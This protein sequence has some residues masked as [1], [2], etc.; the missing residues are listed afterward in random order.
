M[1]CYFLI[2]YEWKRPLFL[3]CFPIERQRSYCYITH[4]DKKL[5]FHTLIN[6]RLLFSSVLKTFLCAYDS[7]FLIKWELYKGRGNSSYKV[8]GKWFKLGSGVTHYYLV[9]CRILCRV[10]HFFI[11]KITMTTDKI[12][13]IPY[14]T[15]WATSSPNLNRPTDTHVLADD[16]PTPNERETT[17]MMTGAS[18][19][20]P[21][22]AV[23]GWSRLLPIIVFLARR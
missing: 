7:F 10:Y 6:Q 3:T 19:L 5:K 17:T 15:R 12:R 9:R 20:T 2:A 8:R 16:I 22:P 4:V 23:S 1:F 18:L 21:V 14:L 11:D 13:M